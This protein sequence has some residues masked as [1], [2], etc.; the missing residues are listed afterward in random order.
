MSVPFVDLKGQ[1]HNI[2]SEIDAAIKRVLEKGQFI[3]G[4]EVELFENEFAAYLDS[5]H[6]VS[7]NSGT[8]ALILG[9]RAL[10]LPSGSEIILPANT[11]YATALA[12][13]ENNLKPIFTD[14]DENDFGMDI[15]DL[16]KKITGKTKAVIAV[17]LYGQ[18][19][20]MDEVQEVVKQS[21]KDIYF[22]EDAAQ[23]H[24]AKLNGKRVGTTGIFAAFSFYPGK[25]LG[26]YGDGGALTTQDDTLARKYRLLREY[27]SEKKYYHSSLGRNSRLDTLQAAILRIKLQ[28]LDK[29][30][31]AR[32]KLA[33]YYTKK[34]SS[35]KEI[36]VPHH[37][38]NRESIYHVYVVRAQKRDELQAYLS[39]KGITTIIHYP[40]PLHVQ[41]A[42][43]YL[44][45]KKGDLPKTEKACEEILSLPMYPE[46][47]TEQADEVVQ[48]I[49]EFYN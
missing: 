16:K 13:S 32:Q 17:H 44:G 21:G 31:S 48:K 27:G 5:K 6:C 49:K 33:A 42:Y 10:D 19:D 29:W 22:V 4:E 36:Q 9:V 37:F 39:S 14:I 28:H 11:F 20:K 40:V 38:Q 46:M 35:V 12:A 34:L 24:G 15:S 47:T 41:E 8:D 26:A 30:N 43:A 25:N 1:Y 3:G 2:Q 18:P 7:M 45:Y 23:T